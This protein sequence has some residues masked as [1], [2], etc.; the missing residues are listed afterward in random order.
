MSQNGTTVPRTTHQGDLGGTGGAAP[1]QKT[2]DGDEPAPE[3]KPP[4]P[5]EVPAPQTPGPD[6]A[7]YQPPPAVEPGMP[8]PEA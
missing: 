1:V 3:I 5:N 4:L 2:R 8:Q 7:P 6:I